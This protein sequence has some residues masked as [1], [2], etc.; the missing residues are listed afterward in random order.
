MA[1]AVSTFISYSR[2]DSDFV[3]R[4]E[5]DL[6]ARGFN[7]W[8]DRRKLEGTSQ[9]QPQIDHAIAGYPLMIVVLSPDAIA[10]PYVRHEYEYAHQLG[11]RIV[12]LLYRPNLPTIPHELSKIQWVDFV[13]RP[14]ETSLVELIDGCQDP[15]F[16]Q[17]SDPRTLY[18]Q[19]HDLESTDPE[20]ATVLYQRLINRAP[21]YAGGRAQVDLDRLNQQLYPQRAQRLREQAEAAHNEGQYGAE[22]GALQALIA[23]GDQDRSMLAWAK[24]YLPIAEQNS[25]WLDTYENVKH[26]VEVDDKERARDL[27]TDLWRK[28]HAPFFRDP[29]GVAPTLGLTV[30]MTYE[31]D[32]ERRLADKIRSEAR[33]LAEEEK[34]TREQTANKAR[35]EKQKAV[36]SIRDK[37]TAPVLADFN[38]RDHRETQ[39]SQKI[40]GTV[41]AM[42]SYWKGG[43][44][45][46]ITQEY[47]SEVE[48]ELISYA[49]DM[50]L[51]PTAESLRSRFVSLGIAIFSSWE[52]NAPEREKL[53]KALSLHQFTNDGKVVP[54]MRYGGGLPF[55][56]SFIGIILTGIWAQ[57]SKDI[58]VIY[59]FIGWIVSVVPAW[60]ISGKISERVVS[61][62]RKR[63]E[64]LERRARAEGGL[65][66]REAAS[67]GEEFRLALERE[68]QARIQQIGAEKGKA[69]APFNAECRQ[70]LT[71]IEDEY[72][73]KMRDSLTRYRQR[74]AEI[75]AVYEQSLADV[76][77]RYASN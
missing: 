55:L 17:A 53:Q 2:T 77:T 28:E 41:S 23:L 32:K 49:Q 1:E 72:K 46:T 15:L 44:L 24:E 20:R 7:T 30:P 4:L 71:E 50:A 45:A 66:G 38:K 51:S 11:K 57:L 58:Y 65:R 9:W 63:L 22:A 12:T 64:A 27:L 59:L 8:V 60:I 69:L 61:D 6:W 43:H 75:D 18:N 10:S 14:Y 56:V 13:N 67:V 5:A 52:E 40:I 16:D 33:R 76:S 42:V 35:Q 68:H 31:E 29:A 70:H 48:H 54:N 73:L 3:D 19:A 37:A 25:A 34:T 26:F 36:R 47:L 62:A 74:I 21:T 39:Q